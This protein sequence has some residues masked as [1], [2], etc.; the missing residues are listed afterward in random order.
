MFLSSYEAMREK[1]LSQKTLNTMAHLGARAFSEIS[2]EVVQT[3]AFVFHGDYF[4]GYKP[5]FFRLVDG[6]EEQKQTALLSGKN[7]FDKT[8]QDDFKKISGSPV[9]YW[10][11]DKVRDIFENSQKLGGIANAV[12]GLQTGDNDQFLRLWHEVEINQI[13]FKMAN[14]EKAK[15]S[16]KKWFPYNKGGSFRKWYGNQDF[17]VNWENDGE[18]IRNF[19]DDKGKQRSRPQNTDYYFQ[20]SVSWS[21]ITSSTN[22]FRFFPEGFIH[23]STGHSIFG[24]NEANRKIVLSFRSDEY[25]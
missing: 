6:N 12:V 5:A 25:Q 22:A 11:S 10:V 15:Q 8:V 13:G 21:D 3:T 17:V 1:L 18:K 14:R 23:D 2:G 7:R 16:G 19:T 4:S 20:E 9:A 24:L